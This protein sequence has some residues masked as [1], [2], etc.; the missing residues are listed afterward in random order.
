[1]HLWLGKRGWCL[2]RRQRA[3][4]E[5]RKVCS[6][7][8]IIEE[9]GL[10]KWAIILLGR[11]APVGFGKCCRDRGLVRGRKSYCK[12]FG[13]G[14]WCSL[15]HSQSSKGCFSW[16]FLK[17]MLTS[18]NGNVISERRF[19]Y[20]FTTIVSKHGDSLFSWSCILSFYNYW[21]NLSNV[22]YPL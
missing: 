18:R 3:I 10:I 21:A 16:I 15:H 4:F 2:L 8:S 9:K 19:Y 20:Y 11:W 17:D 5:K 22:L 14:L 1:M 7:V 6:Y 12:N 13:W